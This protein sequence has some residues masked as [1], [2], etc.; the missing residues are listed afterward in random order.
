[1]ILEVVILSLGYLIVVRLLMFRLELGNFC[2]IR[3]GRSEL[4]SEF[5]FYASLNASIA[6]PDDLT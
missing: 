2:R 6:V 3:S 1:M 5:N 4:I